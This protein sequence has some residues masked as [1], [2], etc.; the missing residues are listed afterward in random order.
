VVATRLV[1]SIE[2]TTALFLSTSYLAFMPNNLWVF[3]P[4]AD[5]SCISPTVL[6]RACATCALGSKPICSGLFET[7]GKT[8]FL[9]TL[10]GTIKTTG[11]KRGNSLSKTGNLR[12]VQQ[13]LSAGDEFG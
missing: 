6:Q 11:L 9:K 7:A 4:I 10:L 2:S 12:W 8:S 1:N 5:G 3:L 13:L